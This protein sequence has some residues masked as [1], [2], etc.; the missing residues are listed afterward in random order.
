[1]E[2]H[3]GQLVKRV[4]LTTHCSIHRCGTAMLATRLAQN[5]TVPAFGSQMPPAGMFSVAKF[6]FSDP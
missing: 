3:F 5:V 4:G 1:M 2:R 6:P